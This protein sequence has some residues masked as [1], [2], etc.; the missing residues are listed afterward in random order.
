MALPNNIILV[1]DVIQSLRA[2]VTDQPQ[3]LNSPSTV[4]AG[5]VS[6]SGST[7]PTGAYFLVAT[8][9][10]PWGET[11]ASEEISPAL[12]VGANQ[13]IQITA[14]NIPVG[15]TIIRVYLTQPGGASGSEQQF[16]ESPVVPFTIS[17][18][19]SAA[20]PP[21]SRNSC[22]LPDSDGDSFN[23][24]LMYQWF[25][26]ALKLSSKI[27]GG[28]MDYGGVGSVS[29]VPMYNVPGQWDSITDTWYDGYPL[30]ADK[31]GNFFRRNSITAN[32]LSS[33]ALSVLSDRLAIEVWPQPA[34]TSAQT[35]LAV[36]MVASDTQAQVAN[37]S[38]F[39]LTNGF[40]Q[41]GTEVCAYSQTS[42]AILLNLFRGLSGTSP[43]QALLLPPD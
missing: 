5:L 25:N 38:N 1:G 18:P 39:L 2:S 31:K 16:V 26:D 6:V 10:N 30:A 42:G 34:R 24:A 17:A 35:T 32:V 43:A 36:A 20:A 3:V 8:F 4:T 23:A 12:T 19:P 14:P 15:A 41:I 22:Y 40:A 21:P 37:I 33:V 11:L 29:G 13:G 9:R 28:L 7:L 27:C